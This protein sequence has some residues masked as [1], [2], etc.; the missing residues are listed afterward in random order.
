MGEVVDTPGGPLE[1][2]VVDAMGV[3]VGAAD[4]WLA[5]AGLDG[6]PATLFQTKADGQGRFRV[7]VPSWL[8]WTMPSM[9]RY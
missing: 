9:H 4:V 5:S 8:K 2:T 1:G 6:W 3:A 7:E